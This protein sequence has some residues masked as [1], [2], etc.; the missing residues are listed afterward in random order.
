MFKSTQTNLV[1]STAGL[2]LHLDTASERDV[3][4]A[5][6][7][8]NVHSEDPWDGVTDVSVNAVH[9]LD[10]TGVLQDFDQ[11]TP[12]DRTL[13]FSGTRGHRYE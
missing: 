10:S 13:F 7:R 12:V 3:F 9:L 11:R 8:T 1:N 2:P 6:V 5:T 4:G